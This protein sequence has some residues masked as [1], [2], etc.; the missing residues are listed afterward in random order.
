MTAKGWGGQ[1]NQETM[2]DGRQERAPNKTRFKAAAPC[3][4]SLERD[5]REREKDGENR[6]G[7]A[8]GKGSQ[9]GLVRG[10]E[11]ERGRE[12]KGGRGEIS[13]P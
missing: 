6:K 11:L 9:R 13:I 5:R 3:C 4:L 12:K 10:N 2:G 1:S 7:E 8:E